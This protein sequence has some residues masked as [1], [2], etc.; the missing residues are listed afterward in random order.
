MLAR[1][2][3]A[4]PPI[5]NNSQLLAAMPT[6]PRVVA[7]QSVPAEDMMVKHGLGQVLPEYAAAVEVLPLK[8]ND[9]ISPSTPTTKLPACQL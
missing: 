6:C 4:A 3:N 5:R 9:P 8:W 2:V 7:S 1:L